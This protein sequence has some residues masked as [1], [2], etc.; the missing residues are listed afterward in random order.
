MIFGRDVALISRNA[1]NGDSNCMP[2]VAPWRVAISAIMAIWAKMAYLAKMANLLRISQS[3]ENGKIFPE[4][5]RFKLDRKSGPLAGGDF[6][7]NSKIWQQW[8]IWHKWRKIARGLAISRMWQIFKLDAKWP[9][10]MR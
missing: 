1:C 5:W 10:E 2:K 3:G 7:E 8:R 4:G 9:L 6:G